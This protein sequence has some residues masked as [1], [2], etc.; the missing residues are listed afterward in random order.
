[1]FGSPSAASHNRFLAVLEKRTQSRLHKPM[2]PFP[3]PMGG[4][5]SAQRSI[6]VEEEVVEMTML[7]NNPALGSLRSSLQPSVCE[8]ERGQIE[9]SVSIATVQRREGTASTIDQ[10]NGGACSRG[11]Q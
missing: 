11:G 1:M 4:R 5:C 7:H 8:R 6:A 3:G 10:H 9:K 2:N